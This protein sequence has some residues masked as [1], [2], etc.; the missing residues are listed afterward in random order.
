M[1]TNI[2]PHNLAE[3]ISA[4]HLLMKNPDV[5]T[6]ELM[7]ALPG[8]DFPTGGLVLGKSGIR[9]AYET[10]RGSIT[11]RGRVQIE[12]LKMERTHHHH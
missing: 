2:P 11:V 9:R 10:G 1:A 6:T 12:E 7:E 8:P 4:L 5:T 3:V